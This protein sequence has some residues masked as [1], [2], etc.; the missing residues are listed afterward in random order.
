[1]NLVTGAYGLVGGFICM[2]LYELEIP[3]RALI[4]NN[5]KQFL[6]DTRRLFN[7]YIKKD[8]RV[9]QLQFSKLGREHTMDM[10]RIIKKY[11]LVLTNFCYIE[12]SI[13]NYN[14]RKF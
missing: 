5:N 11:K 3:Y 2:R 4:R 10:S 7:L 9:I 6:L 1:M 12:I 14:G 8:F 13:I